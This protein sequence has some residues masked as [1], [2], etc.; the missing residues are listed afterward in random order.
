MPRTWAALASDWLSWLMSWLSRQAGLPM[1]GLGWAGLVA[2]AAA[3]AAGLKSI[4]SDLWGV[5]ERV[6]EKEGKEG[7]GSQQFGWLQCRE[8]NERK[9]RR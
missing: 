8:A 1:A 3:A 9:R 7:R 6:R 2:A 5:R 4:G